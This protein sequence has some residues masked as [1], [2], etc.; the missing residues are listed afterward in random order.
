M[1][2]KVV[3]SFRSRFK[4]FDMQVS[5]G[6]AVVTLI[7]LILVLSY[8]MRHAREVDRVQ[9]FGDRHAAIA[10]TAAAGIEDALHGVRQGMKLFL[11]F[12]EMEG[13]DHPSAIE[14]LDIFYESVK[15]TVRVVALLD[16][17]DRPIAIRPESS[18]EADLVTANWVDCLL[19]PGSLREMLPCPFV[20]F[21]D[22]DDA[23][24]GSSF[25]I[26]VK[27]QDH[28][29][30]HRGS[31]VAVLS[32][33]A[34]MDRYAG[35][36]GQ[37]KSMDN[38]LFADDGT[39]MVHSDPHCIG[40]NMDILSADPA[41]SRSWQDFF[42][43]HTPGYGD[44][45]IR[46][47]QGHVERVIVAA[48][49]IVTAD[50]RW[51]IAL[52]TPYRVVVE[53][54]RKVF[55]NIAVGSIG[56]I[57][58]LIV[59]GGAV[60]YMVQ[61]QTKWDEALKRLKEREE[62]QSQ[63]VRE[64]KTVEGIIEGSPVPTMVIGNDH[65]IMFWNKALAELTGYGSGDMVGTDRHYLPL[66]KVKRPLIADII[67]DG[68]LEILDAYYGKKQIQKSETVQDAYEAYDYYENLG[69]KNR[70]LYFLAA[71]IRDEKGNIIAAI[72]TLQDIT[73]EKELEF[74]LK[75]NAETIQ[76]EL[77]VNIRLR[78]EIEGLYTYLQFMIDALPEQ[79]FDIDGEGVINYASRESAAG[80]KPL[81]GTHFSDF[82]SPESRDL[83]LGKW[84]GMKKGDFRAFQMEATAH[85][86][87]RRLLLLT[88]RPI[89]G[90]DRILLI[91]QDITEIRQLQKT[92]FDN[93]KLAALGHLS[94]GIAHELR[95]ALSSIKMSLQV[96]ERRMKPAGNDLKRFQIAQREVEHLSQL[97][98]D[99][100]LF[101]K[102]AEP[103]RETVQLEAILEH[104]M[105]MV[106]KELTDKRILVDRDYDDDLPP[107]DVDQGMMAQA[108]INILINATDAMDER[109]H[110]R[111]RTTTSHRES[112]FVILEIEDDGCGIEEEHM[113]SLFNPFFSRKKYGTGLGLAQ[114]KKIMDVHG[115]RIEIFSAE[116]RGTKVVMMIPVSQSGWGGPKQEGLKE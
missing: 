70:Y 94:A 60:G 80:Q 108:F 62:W 57:I 82:V 73:R 91:Q 4:P 40:R 28:L 68:N 67:V 31:I 25:I 105:L 10:E 20:R 99:V 114:V 74:S 89:P 69:G 48:A 7:I 104:S 96:L 79:I 85:D 100:L 103:E 41:G 13:P 14:N 55:L 37:A 15:K 115:G 90:T 63:L 111:I 86:G 35:S 2:D 95:N 21:P 52:V 87:S 34:I 113:S 92:I 19:T 30:N 53:L 5:I 36:L 54:M 8:A 93:E 78:K 43:S 61:R 58:L 46:D 17:G 45:M 44:F 75:E 88:P 18:A 6:I 110:L 27:R 71:P 26:N 22:S 59:A 49:P 116:G 84:E 107:V 76:N 77:E 65:R 47:S 50:T 102:P 106:E 66:Y 64:T 109:G 1:E 98:R 97:V 9:Q 23:A 112:G 39:I 29:G 33:D 51:T 3:S 11:S 81:K 32:L 72:E 38:W 56:L 16:D 24:A 101:A 42:M 12:M 83:V